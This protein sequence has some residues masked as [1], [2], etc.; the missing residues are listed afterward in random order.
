MDSAKFVVDEK[1]GTKKLNPKYLSG[2]NEYNNLKKLVANSAN[3]MGVVDTDLLVS[4]T[5]QV[6][7][8]YHMLLIEMRVGD[9]DIG[10]T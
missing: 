3:K 9:L 4:L 1:T 10:K 6:S 8:R 7:L 2:I 5:D